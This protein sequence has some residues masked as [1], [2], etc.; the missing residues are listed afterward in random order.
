MVQKYSKNAFS[1]TKKKRKKNGKGRKLFLGNCVWLSGAHQRTKKAA[2][3]M[4]AKKTKTKQNKKKGTPEKN[5]TITQYCHR[6]TINR[7]RE[8]EKR[9]SM[10]I[11]YQVYMYQVRIVII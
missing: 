2:V 5:M 7:S 8:G 11:M 3:S 1:L 6:C 4:K 10:C 9:G